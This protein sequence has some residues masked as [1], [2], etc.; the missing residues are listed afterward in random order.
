MVAAAVPSGYEMVTVAA[1]GAALPLGR[2]GVAATV[3]APA[4]CCILPGHD[5]HTCNPQSSKKSLN[6]HYLH[7]E[8]TKREITEDNSYS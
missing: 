8:E 7:L 2:V 6:R 5:P 3:A 4:E 1:P